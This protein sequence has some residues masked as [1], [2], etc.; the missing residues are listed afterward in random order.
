MYWRSMTKTINSWSASLVTYDISDNPGVDHWY[1]EMFREQG[2]RQSRLHHPCFCLTIHF[3][4]KKFVKFYRNRD[5]D[6]PLD[7]LI[8]QR[9]RT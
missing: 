8:N 4:K 6:S 5:G 3:D 9:V 1:I 7:D 2:R